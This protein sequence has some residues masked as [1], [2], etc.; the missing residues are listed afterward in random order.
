MDMDR[1][2]ESCENVKR[3]TQTIRSLC[4]SECLVEETLKPIEQVINKSKKKRRR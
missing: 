4:N 3:S 1:L 2:K